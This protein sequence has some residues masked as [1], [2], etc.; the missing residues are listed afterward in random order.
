MPSPPLH[1]SPTE[2]WPGSAVPGRGT[3]SPDHRR[4]RVFVTCSAG[5]RQDRLHVLALGAASG[6]VVWQRR[7]I[8]TGRTICHPM[9][10]VSAPTPASDG[11]RVSSY[12]SS[13]DLVALDIA[14]TCSGCGRRAEHP[15]SVNDVGMASSPLIAGDTVIVQVESQGDSFAAGYA[16]DTVP[17]VGAIAAPKVRCQLRHRPSCYAA[18]P[19]PRGDLVLFSRPRDCRR[20]SLRRDARPGRQNAYEV[21]SAITAGDTVFSW[22]R[23]HRA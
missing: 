14:A 22:R 12:F 19:I 2:K 6:Q 10:A 1:W 16:V 23:R 9:T 5:H 3:S 18:R 15:Q 8:A 4:L 21:T 11:Q 7:F 20:S 17:N 13:N